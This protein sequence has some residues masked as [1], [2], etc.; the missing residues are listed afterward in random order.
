MPRGKKKLVSPVTKSPQ[1]ST[2][3]VSKPVWNPSALAGSRSSTKKVIGS[4]ITRSKVP[5]AG[6][7]KKIDAE[8]R[9][10]VA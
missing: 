9:R 3:K 10:D 1:V 8:V 2:P 4:S 7:S 6:E 5:S